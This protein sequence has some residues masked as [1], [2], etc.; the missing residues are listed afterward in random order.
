MIIH[1]STEGVFRNRF[2][3]ELPRFLECDKCDYNPLRGSPLKPYLALLLQ[4]MHDSLLPFQVLDHGVFNLLFESLID[5]TISIGQHQQTYRAGIWKIVAITF[6][7]LFCE[8]LGYDHYTRYIHSLVDGGEYWL[9]QARG[10]SGTSRGNIIYRQTA[11][12][13]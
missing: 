2:M 3:K 10:L 1:V 7:Y 4:T 9:R 5:E 11:R 6:Q 13:Q 8:L 12:Q